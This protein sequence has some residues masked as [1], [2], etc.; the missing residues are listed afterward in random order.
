MAARK[1][2]PYDSAPIQHTSNS[3]RLIEVI[4]QSNG[5]CKYKFHTVRLEDK[6]P[7]IALS[8]AWGSSAALRKINLG[9]CE[10]R[11][12]QNLY[13]AL[14][15]IADKT[16]Q[17][18]SLVGRPKLL[19]WIDA[20]CINQK[21]VLE[22]NHQVHLMS[23]IYSMSDLVL[24][25][26][27]RRADHSELAANNIAAADG[28]ITKEGVKALISLLSRPYWTRMWI[29]QEVIL[30]HEICLLCGED[31]I[32]WDSL[33][34]YARMCLGEQE[35]ITGTHTHAEFSEY[36]LEDQ[37]KGGRDYLSRMGS[38]DWPVTEHWSLSRSKEASVEVDAPLK[39]K[40]RQTPGYD[41]I[42]A[43]SLW[44]KQYSRLDKTIIRWSQR[45]CKDPRDKVF[46]VL[47]ITG[48]TMD[49][50]YE[51]MEADYAKPVE[52]VYKEVLIGTLCS[53]KIYV[54][55]GY[56]NFLSVDERIDLAYQLSSILGVNENHKIVAEARERFIAGWHEI[57]KEGSYFKETRLSPSDEVWELTYVRDVDPPPPQQQH[58]Q[59]DT[60]VSF[61][62]WP[63]DKIARW[64]RLPAVEE[65]DDVAPDE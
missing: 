58:L 49:P 37:V 24:V 62:S 61:W 64:R 48:I 53:E 33:R 35:E 51:D 3:I 63:K 13:D 23:K 34:G 2:S 43:R 30:A 41:T 12:G 60:P 26:L 6:Q 38:T 16:S 55:L 8:Y 45:E 40:L 39:D 42:R 46:A 21:N 52:L 1:P 19:F 31:L 15:S 57:K 17:L 65:R 56:G 28:I 50:Y 7:F 5:S 59:V 27:G 22:R 18:Q 10:F 25:W 14:R 29:V 44:S 36:I 32:S 47:G 20:L 4:Q 9:G 54:K 11:I